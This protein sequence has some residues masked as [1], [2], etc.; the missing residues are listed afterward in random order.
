MNEDCGVVCY[1]EFLPLFDHCTAPAVWLPQNRR[2]QAQRVFDVLRSFDSTP[3]KQIYA[4][5]PD[6]TG[7]GL[8]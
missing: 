4:Q 7:L 3:V 2:E 5:C 1:D 8:P 6:S